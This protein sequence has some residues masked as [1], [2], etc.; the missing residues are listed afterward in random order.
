MEVIFGRSRL[1]VFRLKNRITIDASEIVDSFL[2]HHEFSPLMFAGRHS[3]RITPIVKK[4]KALSSPYLRA[5]RFWVK[6]LPNGN[7]YA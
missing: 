3:S 2:S 5:S 6:N 1:Q 7:R 4:A